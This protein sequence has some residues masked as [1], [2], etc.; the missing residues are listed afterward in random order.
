MPRKRRKTR[1]DKSIEKYNVGLPAPKVGLITAFFF[2]SGATSLALEVAWSKELSY[3]LGVDIYAATTVVT[4]FMAGLGLGALVAARFFRRVRASIRVYGLLQL[5]IGACGMLSIPLFRSTQPLLSILYAHLNYDGGLFLVARF[6]VVFGLMLL[7]VTL[8]GM[9]LPVVVGALAGERRPQFASLAGRLYGVNTLGALSG[10][11]LAGFLLVPKMGLLRTCVLTGMVDFLIGIAVLLAFRRRPTLKRPKP[12][13][14][15][16]GSVKPSRNL[17]EI[18]RLQWPLVIFT[19]SGLAALGVEV[20]WFRILARI[21]GPSVHAFAIMLIMYLAGIGGGSLVGSILVRR[22]ADIRFTTGVTLGACALGILLP[23]IALNEMPLWYANLYRSLVSDGF[24][25][26]LF[27][28]QAILSAWLILP[29]TTAFGMLFPLVAKAYDRSNGNR[30]LHAE[31][32]VGRLYFGNTL[33]AVFGCLLMGF[34]ALP[35]LGVKTSLVTAAMLV[36][37]LSVFCLLSGNTKRRGH[38]ARWGGALAAALTLILMIVP[39][40]DQQLLNAG[41][42][43]DMVDPEQNMGRHERGSLPLG[44]LLM[45]REGVNNSVAV[46]ANKY[47][48]GNLTLHLTGHWVS[49]TEF[50]GRLHLRFL[51]HLPMLFART[52]GSVAVIGYGTGITTGTVLLHPHVRKV[53]VFELEAGVIDAAPYFNFINHHP[54]EDSRTRVFTL[55]G[56]SHLTYEKSTYDVIT[57]D[58]IHPFVAGAANLYS[59]DFYRVAQRRLNKGGVFCQWIPLAAISEEAFKTIL[60]S[61]H[62]IFPHVAIFTF[63]GEAVVVAS[64]QPLDREWEEFTSRFAAPRVKADLESMDILSPYNIKVFLM[65]AGRQVDAYLKQTTSINTDDNAWLEHRIPIDLFDQ[66]TLNL[67]FELESYFKKGRTIALQELFPGLDLNRMRRQ[68]ARLARNGDHAF[69]LAVDARKRQ[70]LQAEERYL[71]EAFSDFNSRFYY[72]AGLRLASLLAHSNRRTEAYSVLHDLQF[73]HPAFPEAFHKEVR[74]REASSRVDRE[75]LR[76]VVDRG[77]LYNPEDEMLQ[78]AWQRQKVSEVAH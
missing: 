64:G 30:S 19:F 6:V 33:G 73:N 15:R 63:F 78:A 37:G 41:L 22:Q 25:G 9:T 31:N 68:L 2:I 34:W 40:P 66:A 77:L 50:H 27:L 39:P 46:V 11:L 7:P 28:V 23:L 14:S 49:T 1:T 51:G 20:A 32:T 26:R 65:G 55:D 3:L 70:D 24:T 13:Q 75:A 60:N 12:T 36:A 76:E 52:P 62:S 69:R 4:A 74:L 48:D 42:Y 67:Y 56:R 8:M 54:L 45:F 72:E 57:A 35:T 38:G 18:G 58:P 61:I 53:D 10:T 47:N 16:P 59:Q 21:I 5:T 17:A 71:W 29:A 44:R 43:T